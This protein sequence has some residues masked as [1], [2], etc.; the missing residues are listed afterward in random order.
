LLFKFSIVFDLFI[1]SF[2]DATLFI[3]VFFRYRPRLPAGFLT[4]VILLTL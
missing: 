1:L 2:I 4:Y 3:L